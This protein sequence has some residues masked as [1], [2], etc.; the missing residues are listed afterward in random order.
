MRVLV[1]LCSCCLVGDAL[2]GPPKTVTGVLRQGWKV[3]QDERVDSAQ[4]LAVSFKTGWAAVKLVSHAEAQEGAEGAGPTECNYPGMKDHP[5]SGVRLMTMSLKDGSVG[6]VF[7]VYQVA[8]KKEECAA[9]KDALAQA[10]ATFESLGL[11][12]AKPPVSSFGPVTRG[13][14]EDLVDDPDDAMASHV[15]V[16]ATFIAKGRTFYQVA[17]TYRTVYAGHAGLNVQPFIDDGKVV[18]FQVFTE[19]SMRS[20]EEWYSFSPVFDLPK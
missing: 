20:F 6:K 19:S 10:K 7:T 18:F 5:T 8:S 4:V 2:A 11:N 15:D 13:G 9:D 17:Y 3:S 1:L 16:T 12:I 14:K